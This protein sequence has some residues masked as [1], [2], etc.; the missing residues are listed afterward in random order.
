LPIEY[1]NAISQKL[2]LLTYF[3]V[4]MSVRISTACSRIL[5]GSISDQSK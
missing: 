1:F 3:I 4:W 2:I 5:E